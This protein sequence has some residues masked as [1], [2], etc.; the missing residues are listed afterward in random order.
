M[1]TSLKSLLGYRLHAR[2]GYIGRVHDFHF[3]N[4]TWQVRHLGGIT[5]V[6]LPWSK[7]LI[8]RELLG[9]PDWVDRAIAVHQSRDEIRQDP[10]IGTDPP[11]YREMERGEQNFAEIAPHWTPLSGIPLPQWPLRS[12]RPVELRSLR[13]LTGYSVESSTGERVG[14]VADFVAADE[15]WHIRLLVV[16]MDHAGMKRDVAI[17]I[18]TVS[19]I[20]FEARTIRLTVD[21]AFLHD[22]PHYNPI[23]LRDPHFAEEFLARVSPHS[24]A[25]K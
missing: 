23:R 9:A 5:H 7:V 15:D 10:R 2:D 22:A 16:D 3:D 6:H 14:R 13:H 25:E 17:D 12:P 11:L 4:A 1:L 24:H 8:A 21:S 19:E 20:L 18:D